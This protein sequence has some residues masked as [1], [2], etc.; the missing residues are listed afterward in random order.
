M[1]KKKKF[2]LNMLAGVIKQIITV[3]CGFILPRYML[4]YY[5][6]AVNGL[7]SSITY[8]LSFISLLDMGV[9]AVIQSNL[10][11]PLADKDTEQIS[12][13]TKASEKFF[14]RLAYI[15]II[16]I[17]FL[18]FAFTTL[19]DTGYDP[20]FTVSLLLII[21]ISTFAQ[22]FFGMTYQLLLNA[23][24]RSYVQLFMQIGTIVLNTV[25]AIVLMRQGASVHA[26]KLMTAFVFVLRPL[27][28]MIYVKKYYNINKKIKV[29][30]EPIKQKWNGFSQHLSAVVCQNVDVAVLTLFSTLE[31]I[32]V[33]S[34]YFNITN[35]ITG[36]I[37]MAATGIEPLFGNMIAK[38]EQEELIRVFDLVEWTVHTG[39]TVIFSIAA[40]LMIPFVSVYTRDI[41]DTN[42]I[43]PLFGILLISSYAAQCLRVPY[44]RV[45]KAAGHFKET[46]NGSYI[47]AI[48]NIII[49]VLLVSKYGLVGAAVGTLVAMLYHTCYFAWYLRKKIL[50]RS[51]RYFCC[52]LLIDLLIAIISYN[53]TKHFIFNGMS[54]HAWILLAIRV[55]PVVIAI[56]IFIN[57]IFFKKRIFH[58]VRLIK[59]LG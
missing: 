22:Y 9:G 28:Q 41:N 23:D 35:G 51:F 49:T 26:V 1:S 50:Y 2:F 25:F 19:L 36:I 11:K 37:M 54:Y 42:Y 47:A 29:I 30:G 7:I 45:I 8:F 3:I 55:A 33:Y 31:N 21:S 27:G 38:R 20:F 34:V 12:R 43:V 24:Q 53:I 40:V 57:L 15:F 52:Y 56:S 48:L 5:G 10:Y 46:Q 32:S 6:S 16:Y 18:C 13:I 17:V 4:L 44:F 39:V 14:R 59:G 58:A